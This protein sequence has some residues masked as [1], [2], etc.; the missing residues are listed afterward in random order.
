[1]KENKQSLEIIQLAN[2]VR[3][4]VKESMTND[5]VMNG[6]K[7]SFYTYIIDRYNGSPTNRAII[8]SYAK[9]IYGKGLTSLQQS[10]K[11]LQFAMVMQKLSKKD[12][13][14]ICQDYALFSEASMEVIYKNGTLDRIKHVPKNQILPNKMNAEGD[15]ETYWYSLDF[16]E[17]RKYKP[18]PIP[19]FNYEK[20]KNGSYIYLINS[21]QVGKMY[22]T[23][24]VY[25]AGLPY[26]ELEEEIAN[27]CINHIKN[28]LSFGHIFNMNQGE[29]SPEVKRTM[30]DIIKREGQ[31]SINAGVAL[32]NW[33]NGK[34]TGIDVTALEVS[35]AHQ[36]YEFLTKEAT[37][38]LLI[39]HKVTSPILFGIKDNTGMG[40]NAN[41]MESAFNELSIN[42]ITP[43]KETI[44]DCLMELFSDSGITIDL[45]FI[46]L[47]MSDLA[48]NDQSYNGAQISSAVEIL[49]SVKAGILTKEQ[50]IVFLVQ[51][52]QIPAAVAETLFTNK[53]A[54]LQQLSSDHVDTDPIIA[55]ALINL[56]E[57]M[58]DEW[59]LIDE[60]EYSEHSINLSET[61]LN[62]ASVITN[63]PLAPS[64][65][66]NEYFKVRFEY[67]GSLKPQRDF[68]KKMINAGR[69]YRKE[70]IDLASSQSVNPGF[71]PEGTDTYDILKYK[72]GARCNHYFLRKVYL[73]K[74]NNYIT[75]SDAQQLI[76]DLKQQ[77][78]QTEIPTSGEPLSTIKPNNMPNN[79]FL[80]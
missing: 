72:G 36:Q 65:I 21:Y 48:K 1:M 64:S 28:G 19:A 39:S 7:N 56:G 59:E 10:Q 6:P 8:D 16:N 35:D 71:G 62:L 13:K 79:G 38:K 55:D 42:V 49:T 24:P 11:P 25:M 57:V 23:D 43:M 40:N 15:I 46:P 58:S 78:I 66:D 68:C 9:F 63:I 30:K 53:P 27:Y 77:G 41:E 4:V 37:Q 2:Y 31:G 33:N 44:L 67:A 70:D 32:I 75:V 20:K 80:N 45:D 14:N 29:P 34:D 12:L 74:G 73:K 47:R 26:A 5:F 60:E 17:P 69:V 51:F 54:D 61:S 22:F 76:R 3:P 50:A 18:V 52:L